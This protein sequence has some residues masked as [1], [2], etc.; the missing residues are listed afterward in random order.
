MEEAHANVTI[1]RSRLVP[2]YDFALLPYGGRS[3]YQ[4][5][6]FLKHLVWAHGVDVAFTRT[7]EC[8]GGI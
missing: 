4:F 7:A 2:V 3:D 8:P 5:P 1:Y 6:N